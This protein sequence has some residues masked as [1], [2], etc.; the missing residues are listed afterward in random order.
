MTVTAQ[1]AIYDYMDDGVETFL[2]EAPFSLPNQVKYS[3]KV[4]TYLDNPGVWVESEEY[5]KIINSHNSY[6]PDYDPNT[7]V[8]TIYDALDEDAVIDLL[9]TKLISLN[10]SHM[11]MRKSYEKCIKQF[12]GFPTLYAQAIG[13]YEAAFKVHMPSLSAY[14]RSLCNEV[15]V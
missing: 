9:I 2:G 11:M 14:L 3:N 6:L 4:Y 13:K 12:C 15:E 8:W 1:F 10:G 7:R 5:C